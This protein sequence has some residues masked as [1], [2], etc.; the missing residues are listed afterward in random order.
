[1][2]LLIVE[3]PFAPGMCCSFVITERKRFVHGAMTV[4][5]CRWPT[6]GRAA[7]IGQVTWHEHCQQHLWQQNVDDE[8][9]Q[10]SPEFDGY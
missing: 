3:A 2:L 1:M 6:Q 10:H 7:L 8:V 4:L 9:L 5:F